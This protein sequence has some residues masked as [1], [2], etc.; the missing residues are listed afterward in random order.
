M[1]DAASSTPTL[2]EITEEFL[3]C[4]RCSLTVRRSEMPVHLAHAH[5]IGPAREKDK[6]KARTK[7]R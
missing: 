1:T 6:K 5:N 4:G 7:D 3:S 2:P